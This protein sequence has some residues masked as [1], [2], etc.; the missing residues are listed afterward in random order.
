MSVL[1]FGALLLAPAQAQLARLPPLPP[2]TP[3][4]PA[5]PAPLLV[6]PGAEQPVRLQSVQIDAALGGGL[7]RTTLR[8]VFFNPNRRSLEGQLQF[9]LLPGQQ[10]SAFALD[11]EGRLR[12]AVP[13]EKARGR[14]ILESVERR[15]VDPALLEQTQGNNFQ[16]R[17]Y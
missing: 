16:L 6:V 2:F 13:V 9:P 4:T 1:F 11:I 14:E 5:A 10:V 7:A 15:R 8:L 3:F 12:A 17:V